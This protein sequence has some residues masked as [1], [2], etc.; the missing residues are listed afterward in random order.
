MICLYFFLDNEN[1]K[2][3]FNT[4]ES[5]IIKIIR[6]DLIFK[7]LHNWYLYILFDRLSINNSIHFLKVKNK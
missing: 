4:F 3:I 6:L 7:I 2:M 1:F 5:W